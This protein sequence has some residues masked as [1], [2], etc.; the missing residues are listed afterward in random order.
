MEQEAVYH[1]QKIPKWFFNRIF[2]GKS[3][4]DKTGLFE[5]LTGILVPR[6]VIT[7]LFMF[8]NSASSERTRRNVSA[9]FPKKHTTPSDLIICTVCSINC[10]EPIELFCCRKVLYKSTVK[11][12]QVF[13]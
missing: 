4:I 9:S 3:E 7:K 13:L 12:L 1:N 2:C 11:D 10:S 5:E 6:N 8:M